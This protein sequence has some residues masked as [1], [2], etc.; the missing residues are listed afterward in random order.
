[1]GNPPKRADVSPDEEIDDLFLAHIENLYYEQ[2]AGREV[3]PSYCSEE[4]WIGLVAWHCAEKQ[5]ERRT[6]VNLDSLI[7]SLRQQQQ[8]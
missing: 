7:Q 3:S 6:A 2:I 8:K 5:Y 4:V 1:M